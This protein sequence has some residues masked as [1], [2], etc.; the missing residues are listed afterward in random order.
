[1]I[2]K[3]NYETL[4]SDS[5]ARGKLSLRSLLNVLEDIGAC[6]SDYVQNNLIEGSQEGHAWVL[7]DWTVEICRQL[8]PGEPVCVS[9]WAA[10]KPGDLIG[11]REI[12]TVTSDGEPVA[13]AT[14]QMVIV[15]RNKGRMIRFPE[16][17][18]RYEP[19]PPR[20]P[21]GIKRVKL[22]KSFE[23][24]QTLAVRKA[25]IDYNGHVHNTAYLDYAQEIAPELPEPKGFRIVY[26]SSAMPGE[27]L[28]LKYHREQERHVVAIC[29]EDGKVSAIVELF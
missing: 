7:S 12:D 26:K 16:S 3:K 2:F 10:G 18:L 21:A 11:Y 14:G 17:F 28:T 8:T 22:P 4:L 27:L 15:D 25:D 1:M 19:E 29:H 24:E 20:N 13:H 5:D 6:H 9:T 23:L